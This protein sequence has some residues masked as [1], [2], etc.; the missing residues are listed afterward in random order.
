MAISRYSQISSF[1]NND[2]DYK[3]VFTKRYGLK[4]GIVMLETNELEYPD[5]MDI[6]QLE[7]R[8][9]IWTM[10]D[11]YYKLA[12]LYYGDPQYWWI[13]A[14]FN[15]KPTEHHVKMGDLIRVPVPLSDVLSYMGV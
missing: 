4:K 1:F 9:H 15:K 14:Q 12:N 7:M 8:T 11:R 6:L 3:H 5:F 10:G 13:I 2:L